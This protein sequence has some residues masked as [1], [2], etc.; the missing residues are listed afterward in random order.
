MKFVEYADAE[1][2]MIDLFYHYNSNYHLD[3]NPMPTMFHQFLL[4]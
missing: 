1:M 3:Y 2:M 4:N